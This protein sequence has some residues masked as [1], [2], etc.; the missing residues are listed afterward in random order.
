[1]KEASVKGQAKLLIKEKEVSITKFSCNA[2]D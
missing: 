1:M 2:I